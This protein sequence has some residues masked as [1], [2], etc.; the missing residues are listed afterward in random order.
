MKITYK[1]FRQKAYLF[2]FKLVDNK[3]LDLLIILKRI[4]ILTLKLR[5]TLE[6]RDAETEKS[7]I[8][9]VIIEN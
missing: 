1:C 9:S 5:H 8:Y 2:N 4:R 6:N 7:T 3:Q